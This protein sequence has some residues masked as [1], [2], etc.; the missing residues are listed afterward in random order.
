MTVFPSS[1]KNKQGLFFS[2][3]E[4]VCSL[5]F[6]GNCRLES[7]CVIVTGMQRI[8][9]K[10]R[11]FSYH[12]CFSVVKVALLRTGN[13]GYLRYLPCGVFLRV[14]GSENKCPSWHF[15]N[16]ACIY[17]AFIAVLL[18]WRQKRL[19]PSGGETQD[20]LPISEIQVTCNLTSVCLVVIAM[21]RALVSTPAC[22]VAWMWSSSGAR[23]ELAGLVCTTAMCMSTRCRA[24]VCGVAD[25]PGS[26]A[27]GCT[28]VADQHS[29]RSL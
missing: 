26:V 5:Y 6:T 19:I 2:Q 9:R 20:I 23:G 24:C 13:V 12:M 18:L 1:I 15:S 3:G 10:A 22:C 8:W 27:G 11:A 16:K 7:S 21:Q 29:W 17:K 14:S 25:S 28:L 4:V